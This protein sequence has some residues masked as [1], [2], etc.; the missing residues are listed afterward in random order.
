MFGLV[1]AVLTVTLGLSQHVT[2]LGITLFASCLSYF[3]FRLAV[4]LAA[5]A[6]D[7][8]ALPAARRPGLSPACPSSAPPL[9][10]QTAPTY[11]SIV[12]ALLRWA[13]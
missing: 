10:A 3:V 11:L 12:L 8:R 9:F 13:I 2:G 4:P 1:H 7:G 6:A 5:H